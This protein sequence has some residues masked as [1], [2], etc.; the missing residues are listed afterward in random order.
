MA[1]AKCR[2]YTAAVTRAG[3]ATHNSSREA[4]AATQVARTPV[5][6]CTARQVAQVDA[7]TNDF[8]AAADDGPRALD[9]VGLADER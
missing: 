5:A 7:A 4:A 9:R 6:G 1:A 2:A 3:R 8:I